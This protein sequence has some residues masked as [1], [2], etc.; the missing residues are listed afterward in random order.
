MAFHAPVLAG[1][2]A[3]AARTERWRFGF[4]KGHKRPGIED[5]TKPAEDTFARRSRHNEV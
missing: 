3:S 1:V 4:E 5:G 2:R